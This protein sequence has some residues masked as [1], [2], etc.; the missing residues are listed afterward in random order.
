MHN[1]ATRKK[2]D[3]NNNTGGNIR[4]S[5]ENDEARIAKNNNTGGNIRISTEH[6]EARM[7]K[8]ND[9]EHPKNHNQE[10]NAENSRGI[11]DM[12]TE[13]QG[14]Q[15]INP[16]YK[17]SLCETNPQVQ[18]VLSEQ[19]T[20]FEGIS[21]LANIAEHRITMR[22]DRPIKQRY[23]PKN[24]AMQRIIDEQVDALLEQGCIEPSRSPEKTGQWRMCVDYRQ[25]NVKSI[26]D[27]YPLPR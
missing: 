11:P 2:N 23:F 15:I 24:P 19:V 26:P 4:I 18:A 25:L 20:Q 21:G 27:A 10:K 12:D 6:D 5:T 22:D 16:E 8:N 17:E 9:R 13:T 7:A 1:A 3:E 14:Y